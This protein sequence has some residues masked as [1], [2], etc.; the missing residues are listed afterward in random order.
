MNNQ[1][2]DGTV[3]LRTMLLGAFAGWLGSSKFNL[4]SEVT[5]LLSAVAGSVYDIAAYYIKNKF[6]GN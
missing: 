2:F 6:K 3:N 5:T 1:K 4:P